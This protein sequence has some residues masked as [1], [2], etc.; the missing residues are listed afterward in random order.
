MGIEVGLGM[1]VEKG[2]SEGALVGLFQ[3]GRFYA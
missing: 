3:G 1:A 2:F